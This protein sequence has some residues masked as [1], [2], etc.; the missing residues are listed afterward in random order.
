MITPALPYIAHLVNSNNKASLIDACLTLSY[1]SDG[2]DDRIQAV[3]DTGVAPALVRLLGSDST[4]IVTPAL[5]TL[6]NIVSGSDH[7]TQA[8]IDA[9]VLDYIT[10]LLSSP[11]KSV[12]KEACWLISNIAAGNHSQITKLIS[13]PDILSV[14][15]Q[16]V[17]SAEWD[18]RKEATWV[19]SN[20][21]TGG[22]DA[23]VHA[24]VELGSINALVEIIS[25]ADPKILLVVLDAIES[26]LRV[27]CKTGRDYVGFV[28][29]CDGLDKI[30][31]LQEHENEEVY[32]KA[33]SIIE[34]YFGVEEGEDQNLVPTVQGDTFAFGLPT[35]D[36][37]T[38]VTAGDGSQ[39]HQQVPLQPF[40]FYA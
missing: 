20:I 5:R 19:L 7:H 4:S 21:A 36:K 29:E 13:R 40:N 10:P 1:I 31:M 32:E 39:Q 3:V 23:H 2:A 14:V 8:V 37:N 9:G 27:G 34:K 6:G 12:K 17:H 30:E 38:N 11:K 16:L 33:I 24:L 25:V 22:E 35:T 28:D 15:I 26:I 18:V